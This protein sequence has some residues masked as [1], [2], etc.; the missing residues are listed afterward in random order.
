MA[1]ITA[2][3]AGGTWSATTAWV[4]GVVPGVG[5]DVVLA[6]TSGSL[7][8]TASTAIRSLSCT[9]Y[10]GTLTHNAA[11]ILTI[12]TTTANGSLAFLLASTMTYTLGSATTSQIT[13]ADNSTSSLQITTGGK[14]L[15]FLSCNPVTAS[16]YTCQDALTCGPLSHVKGTFATGNFAQT[17]ST[18]TSNSGSVRT[19]TLGSSAISLASGNSCWTTATASLTMT[20]NTA[21]ITFTGAASIVVATGGL[22]FNGTSLVNPLNA[23]MQIT[24]VCTVGNITITD[25]TGTSNQLITDGFTCTNLTMTANAAPGRL[26]LRG[27]TPGTAVTVTVNGTNSFQGVDFQD[28]TAAGTASWNVSAITWGAG[29]CGGNTGITFAAAITAHLKMTAGASYST[30][31]NWYLATN[32]GGGAAGRY[33]L[34]HDTA[35]LDANSGN[36]TLTMDTPRVAGMTCTGFPGTVACI[37]VSVNVYGSLALGGT[38]S[39]GTKNLGLTG[40]GAQTLITNGVTYGTTGASI[41]VTAPGG[42]YTLTGNL[43]IGALATA[44]LIVNQGTLNLNGYNVTASVLTSTGTLTR[45]ITLGTG[46][47][48][49]TGTGNVMNLTST[50]MTWSGAS[51]IVAITDTSATAKTFIG[52]SL[53][54]GNLTISSGASQSVIIQGANTFTAITQSGAGSITFPASTTTTILPNGWQ[55]NGTAGNIATIISSTAGTAATISIASGLAVLRYGSLKDNTGTGGATFY[56]DGATSSVVSNVTG[57]STAYA[58][59]GTVAGTFT[60]S[61][62]PPG[63]G[64][65]SAGVTATWTG[66]F[67]P[68]G[69]GLSTGGVVATYTATIRGVVNVP[70]TGGITITWAT[71]LSPP[72]IGLASAGLTATFV[73]ALAP[74]GLGPANAALS[75]SW[76]GSLAGAVNVPATGGLTSAYSATLTGLVQVPATS[77]AVVGTFTG[78]LSGLNVTAYAIGSVLITATLSANKNIS[79]P[80]PGS[81]TMTDAPEWNVALSDLAQFSVAMREFA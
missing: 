47:L 15:G 12:G 54:H 52:A 13:L 27:T 6:S 76:A 81:V 31:A 11:V 28:I 64:P 41:T 66:S 42:T 62:S 7:T 68:V 30:A 61:F 4:G 43:T 63:I 29:D 55:V 57:W 36:F 49:L 2:S 48:T 80:H 20:A 24:G 78:A 56:Y 75:A 34:A 16:T 35:I 67:S 74:P 44:G 73:A 38:W 39:T 59:V 22:N 70:A 77:S 69:I 17:W 53:A 9:G 37:S 21:V 5:D 14:V 46:T 23:T 72:G 1:T 45:G 33:P 19:L 40:R 79:G 32:G 25:T 26:M 3:A 60:G 8:L 18:F 58:A 71:T 10:T 50:G 65:A 51:A